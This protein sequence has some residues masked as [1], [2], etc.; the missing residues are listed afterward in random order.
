V[1][2]S[3]RPRS[4][5]LEVHHTGTVDQKA[6]FACLFLLCLSRLLA[7]A[8]LSPGEVDLTKIPALQAHYQSE[9]TFDT[10][11]DAASWAKLPPGLHAAFGSTDELYLRSEL[12][13]LSAERRGWEESGWRGERLNAQVLVWSTSSQ[14]QV[15]VRVS[16][17]RSETGRSIGTNRFKVQLVRYVLS[18]F[19]YRATDFDCNVTND[20]AFLMPDRFEPFERFNLPARSVRPV[21]LSIEIPTNAAPGEYRGTVHVQ[22]LKEQ[23]SL[24]LRVQVQKPVLPDSHDWKFRLDLWQN[25]W[26]LASHFQVP[27]WSEEHQALLRKHLKLYAE[28]GGKCLTTYAMHSPWA[29][30]SYTVEGTMI[31]WIKTTGGSW[32]FD[33]NIFDQY[34]QL[35]MEA[36]VDEAITIYTPLPWANRVRYLDERSGN[37]VQEEWSPKSAEYQAFW[38]AFLDDL[39]KHLTKR[40][41]LQKTYLG[42][43]ENPME[44]TLAAINV[45][46]AHSK[47]WRITYA[48]DWHGELSA[49]LDDYSVVIPKEP[50]PAELHE[51]TRRGSTTTFYVCCN[52]AQ[53]NTF[54]FS[55]PVEGRYLGW[56][57]A[58]HGY[59]G[60]LRWAYD[61]WPADPMRDA[62]HTLWPAGDC[63]LVYPGAQSSIRFEKLREGIVDFEKIRLLRT[64]LRQSSK[65]KPTLL[66]KELDDHLS[67][68]AGEHDFDAARLSKSVSEGRSLI[69]KISAELGR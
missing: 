34:V 47:D 3:V 17:L 35:A 58:A 62:R 10:N 15:R 49:L 61:A 39:K 22:S 37:F 16:E 23:A 45:I 64:W 32:K 54:V 66:I 60:F 27:P 2:Q 51:R 38:Y 9:F 55:A 42:I 25:P 67:R 31:G 21:W 5:Q 44:M 36:G 13:A 53:P 41:W 59:N 48:G 46:K 29:D 57:A 12:P 18:N 33:Y 26:V 7:A 24:Q 8:Q 28:A 14:G 6:P 40:G 69:N 43:N 30:N 50:A 65:E 52:P 20:R 1:R 11:T 63:F 56:Y 68:M 4:S 19:P